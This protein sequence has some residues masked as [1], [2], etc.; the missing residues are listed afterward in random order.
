VECV[1]LIVEITRREMVGTDRAVGGKRNLDVLRADA[2]DRIPSPARSWPHP[3]YHQPK[4]RSAL[5]GR[6]PTSRV[7]L[8]PSRMSVTLIEEFRKSTP[9]ESAAR[10]PSFPRYEVSPRVNRPCTCWASRTRPSAGAR[11]QTQGAFGPFVRGR[12][13]EIAVGVVGRSCL[14]PRHGLHCECHNPGVPIHER[15]SLVMSPDHFG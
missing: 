10:M 6:S 12:I 9:L 3:A 14:R 1:A 4:I 7:L 5:G 2:Q 8:L 15:V 11:K 13:H